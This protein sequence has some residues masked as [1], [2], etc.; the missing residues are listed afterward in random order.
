MN[1]AII[2]LKWGDFIQT[3][4]GY[5]LNEAEIGNGDFGVYS[6]EKPTD[7]PESRFFL[8]RL[9]ITGEKPI[10]NYGTLEEARQAAEQDLCDAIK[11][12]FSA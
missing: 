6:I 11:D 10:G 7:P 12:K 3:K 5:F 9:T 4:Q 1:H 8:F 2:S